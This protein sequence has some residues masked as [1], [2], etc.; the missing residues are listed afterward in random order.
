MKEARIDM[1]T[2]LRLAIK[3]KDS[4]YNK[5]KR[6]SRQNYEKIRNHAWSTK[7]RDF[8]DK[9]EAKSGSKR[10][11]SLIKYNKNTQLGTVKKPNGSLTENP[12]ETLDVTTEVHFATEVGGV[13]PP[14]D[15]KTTCADDTAES[16]WGLD[17]RFSENRAKR[18]L[19]EF[20]YCVRALN[21]REQRY[22]KT[23]TESD[24]DY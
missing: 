1:R 18:A 4:S 11:S 24:N 16:R 3:N 15:T 14:I 2:K 7:F 20:E 19:Q 5:T 21:R 9:L 23:N 13:Y 12:S 17:H 8:C 22:Q 6:K 10:I